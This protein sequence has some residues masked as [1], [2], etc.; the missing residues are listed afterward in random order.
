MQKLS[1]LSSIV[2]LYSISSIQAKN[3]YVHPDLGSDT[4]TGT[5]ISRPFKTLRKLSSLTFQPK[6]SIFLAAGYTFRGSLM[7]KNIHGKPG[8]P[9]AITSYGKRAPDSKATIDA[10][11]YSNAILLENCSFIEV[12]DLTVTA[13]GGSISPIEEKA[14]GMR[15]GVLILASAAGQYEHFRLSNLTVKNIFYDKP[16]FVRGKG[17]VNT[18]NGTQPYGWGIRLISEAG[19]ILN[20]IEVTGCDISN[21]GH[22]GLKFTG[23]SHSIKNIYIAG[24]RITDTGGPGMQMS[25]VERGIVRNNYVDGS[26]STKDSRNWGRGSGLWTWGTR[27]V[28]IEKNTFM[29]AN[30]PGDSA[31]CHID[32]NCSDVVV[33]YNLSANNAGG[34]CEILGNNYNC[35]YR[36]N[37]SVNDG[38]R[39][40][41][42]NGAFQEG[43]IF[44]L[45]GYIGNDRKPKGPYN[46]YFYNNTI[47][48]RAGLRSQV[49][50]SASASGILIA[51]N[52][53]Y[54]E[55]ESKL[56]EGD[57]LKAETAG[58]TEMSNSIFRNN[59]Y[60]KQSNWPEAAFLQDTN[61]YIGDPGFK[62]KGGW[63]IEDYIPDNQSLVKDKGIVIP[64]L[65]N[66]GVGLK[67][68]L[69]AERD[70][71]DRKINGKPDLGAIELH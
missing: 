4:N 36:Y 66:D 7:L 10:K 57:Q 29:N 26:G 43:K 15:C 17:E 52:I 3:Y 33:Q 42:K 11:G 24:N 37:I 35:A 16:G 54:I 9:I 56:V 55:G 48:V 65:P 63:R 6:D 31:G 12:S 25:G 49:A 45:S 44:W 70:I 8:Q 60:L 69:R 20:K 1:F 51:N 41:G 19:S 40:K 39:T 46:S 27:E 18:A 50:I 5:S 14:T 71:L 59:L 30:G 47:Y 23:K 2:F 53:F 28:I 64:K 67:A 32:Y 38:Y 68:G 22:T 58:T 61:P 34:F 13:N 21:T 62:N